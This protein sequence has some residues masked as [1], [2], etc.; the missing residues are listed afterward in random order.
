MEDAEAAPTNLIGFVYPPGRGYGERSSDVFGL[1]LGETPEGWTVVDQHI[2]S[3]KYFSESDIGHHAERY[4]EE[5][6]GCTYQWLG[7]RT[8]EWMKENYPPAPER[9]DGGWLSRGPSA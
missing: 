8:G 1:L 9:E 2:S 6:A 5:Y 3:S 7:E 4:M